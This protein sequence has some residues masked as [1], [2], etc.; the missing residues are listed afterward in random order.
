M[1]FDVRIFLNRFTVFTVL[2]ILAQQSMV[3]SATYL[4]TRLMQA[5]QSGLPIASWLYAYCAAML[6]PYVPGCVGHIFLQSWV[7]R[8][9]ANYVMRAREAVRQW[10]GRRVQEADRSF[11]QTLI[12]K[13]SYTLI[14]SVLAFV[15]GFVDFLASSL[16]NVLVLA[17]LLPGDLAMGYALSTLGCAIALFLL[18]KPIDRL[19]TEQE[20]QHVAMSSSLTRAWDN[21]VL[22][23]AHNEQQWASQNGRC[24][25]AFYGASMSLTRTLWLSNIGL[26]CITLLP[27]IYLIIAT[28]DTPGLQPVVAAALIANL[29]RIFH[30]LS[31]VTALVS[32]A[33]ACGA[34]FARVR[35]LFD[36]WPTELPADDAKAQSALAQALTLNDEPVA[37]RDGAMMDLATRRTGR[38][39]L[40]GPNGAGKSTFLRSL[41]RLVGDRGFYLPAHTEGLAW[42]DPCDG[43]STG[44]RMSRHLKEI[45]ELPGVTHLILDE[46]DAN[47]DVANTAQF[48]ALLDE[49]SQSRL[50]IEIRH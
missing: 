22:G 16:F 11:M 41:K 15:H 5:F 17:W 7:N 8:A 6:L 10:Q 36:G 24:A 46:W 9:H 21:V 4:L 50:V 29:T 37:D 27:P 34:T 26:A 20:S 44:Q 48:D 23:N 28:L 35:I 19:A 2:C 38:V 14:E 25:C 31:G 47:L 32:Q 30:V 1:L 40:R 43:C 3:A 33:I 18:K 13:Q 45:G 39:T 42:R 49:W 12:G